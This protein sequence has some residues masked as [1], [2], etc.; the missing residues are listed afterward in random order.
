M[1]NE[2]DRAQCE[3]TVPSDEEFTEP[4]AAP[5]PAIPQRS[6]MPQ[7]KRRRFLPRPIPQQIPVQQPRLLIRSVHGH[8]HQSHLRS[9]QPLKPIPNGHSTDSFGSAVLEKVH[10]LMTASLLKSRQSDE[11]DTLG[12]FIGDNLRNWTRS[13]PKV[14]DKFRTQAYALVF[15]FQRQISDLNDVAV[16]GPEEA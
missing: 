3:V 5:L 16:P 2:A 9:Q 4:T 8:T 14:A 6:T 1:N 12:K 7:L 10:D 11:F 13:H 15:E